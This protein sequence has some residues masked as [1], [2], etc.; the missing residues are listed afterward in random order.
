MTQTVIGIKQNMNDTNTGAEYM[1]KYNLPEKA[2]EWPDV[3]PVKEG[4]SKKSRK[5][6][7]TKGAK[8]SKKS[9][10]SKKNRKTNRR[11]RKH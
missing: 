4:G 6:R 11:T 5:S 1:K 2:K 10:K 8:K 7:K 3:D 9:K